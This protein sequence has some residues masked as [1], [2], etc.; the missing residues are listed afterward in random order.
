VLIWS[1]RSPGIPKQQR[2]PHSGVT[3]ASAPSLNGPYLRHFGVVLL[4]EATFTLPLR[5]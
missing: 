3:V 4:D 1:P 2:S 5:D